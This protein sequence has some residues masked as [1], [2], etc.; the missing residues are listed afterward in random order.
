MEKIFFEW[1]NKKIWN[2][3]KYTGKVSESPHDSTT[4]ISRLDL[5]T[6]LARH[7]L[8]GEPQKRIQRKHYDLMVILNNPGVY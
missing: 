3:K 5:N 8:A 7:R 1:K 4:K 6:F 2:N